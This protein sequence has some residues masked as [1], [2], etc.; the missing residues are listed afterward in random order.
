MIRYPWPDGLRRDCAIYRRT[1][2]EIETA[3]GILLQKIHR[4][5][6]LKGVHCMR[7][8]NV[9]IIGAG[10]SGLMAAY[11]LNQ[12]NSECTIAILE[13][14][15]PLA[16]RICP[17]VEN[18][19]DKCLNCQPC[20]I[21][22]GVAG[23]GAKND[24][25]YI[26]PTMDS[27]DYG[28]WLCNYHESGC[29]IDYIKQ[30][31]GILGQFADKEY[32]I[33]S[34][35]FEFKQQCLKNDL[36]LQTAFIRHYGS[37][38][39]YQVMSGLIHDLEQK[40]IEIF[41]SIHIEDIDIHRKMVTTSSET[42]H[43]DE[44]IVAVGRTGTPWFE[45]FCRKNEIP[46]ENNRVD[47][48]VRVEIRAEICSELAKSI[49]EP[50]I[51]YRSKA[52]GDTTR[53]FCWNNGD[54]KVCI[55][56]NDGVLSVNGYANSSSQTNSGNSNFALL[57]SINFSEPFKQPTE[58]ARYIAS[59]SNMISG[60][61]V[62]VQR[63]GDLKKGQR[64]N[65]HRLSHSTTI[66]SLKTAVAGDISLALP[67]RILDDIIETLDALNNVIQGINNYDTLLYS[68]EIKTYSARPK[69]ISKAF[70]IADSV[71]GIGDGVGISRSLSQAGAMGLITADAITTQNA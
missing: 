64:T 39:N 9:V 67:K 63:L 55:E 53:T 35:S 32:K 11:R 16:A 1:F 5:Y 54:A 62:L 58:Y 45:A 51:F 24:G 15:K 18:R 10:I 19:A 60:N 20:A 48:G 41:T 14:G 52:Y 21:V 59:L 43:Y 26:I 38:G 2:R 31:D 28:G 13:K 25:K 3:Q 47:V 44:L 70:E 42:Y 40:G 4:F 27:T 57:T 22:S 71:Y 69:K 8:Y 17:I 68:P 23:A 12:N 7:N 46:L 37:D 6:D 56:N 50:K 66:P 65:D 29:V 34:P 61:S 30:V 33:Y 49:Y 36:H